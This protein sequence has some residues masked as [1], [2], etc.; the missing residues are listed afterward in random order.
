MD[1]KIPAPPEGGEESIYGAA[2]NPQMPPLRGG[3]EEMENPG[4]F[5]MEFG[6][7]VGML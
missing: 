1:W 2:G 7:A 6:M 5:H 3:D 4:L